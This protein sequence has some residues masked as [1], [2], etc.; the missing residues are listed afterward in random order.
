MKKIYRLSAF[1][2]FGVFAV[3]AFFCSLSPARAQDVT[4]EE[5]RRLQGVFQKTLEDQQAQIAAQTQRP[6]KLVLKGDVTVEPAQSYYAITLPELSLEYPGGSH[7]DIG[8][9]SLNALPHEEA[10]RFKMTMAMP[11]PILGFNAAGQET[12]RIDI[13]FQKAAGIWHEG[14]QNFITLD[15]L[16]RNIEITFKDRKGDGSMSIGDLRLRYDLKEDG[17]G[18]LSGPS[19]LEISNID[20][21]SARGGAMSLGKLSLSLMLDKALAQLVQE[22]GDA[23]TLSTINFAEGM[24]LALGL[25][26]FE[27]SSATAPDGT[28]ET[29]SLKQGGIDFSY[30]KGSGEFVNADL[31]FQF[32]GAAAGNAPPE[33]SELLPQSGQFKLTHHNIPLGTIN[34]ALANSGQMPGVGLLLKLPAFMAEAGSYLE[35]RETGLQNDHYDIDM[36]MRVNADLSA[37]NSATATGTLRF[38]GLDKTLSL[39]QAASDDAK[40]PKQAASMRSLAGFL[41]GL[42]PAGRV[43][44]TDDGARGPVHIFDLEMNKT[45]QILI[46]GQNAFSLLGGAPRPSAPQAQ[47]IQPAPSAQD[48]KDL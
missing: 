13:G 14:L 18:R 32:S 25:D 8:L 12:M 36:D 17:P 23:Q 42:K 24:E 26:N 10:G 43:E 29:L 20:M 22:D 31:G 2:V 16:Y 5:A 44:E 47:P 34:E 39:A 3:L 41:E 27:T 46:N 21:T 30:G 15:S 48:A 1:S 40:N 9:I 11:T 28:Q 6:R 37:A 19:R 4:E 45:G 38:A 33:L 7:L 35:L